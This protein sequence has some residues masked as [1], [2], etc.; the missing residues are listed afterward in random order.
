MIGQRKRKGE[1]RRARAAYEDRLS[2]FESLDDSNLF[3]NLSNPYED[4]TVNTQAA[5]FSSTA[6]TTRLASYNASYEWCC[7]W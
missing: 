2:Q 1:Q 3:A 5:E 7:W 4:A 6:T